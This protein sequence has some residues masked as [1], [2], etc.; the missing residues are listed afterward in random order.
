[1]NDRI[2]VRDK[3]IFVIVGC[4]A[5]IMVG[6][7]IGEGMFGGSETTSLEIESVEL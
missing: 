3:V 4:D 5:D 6:E 2:H 1:M 7:L